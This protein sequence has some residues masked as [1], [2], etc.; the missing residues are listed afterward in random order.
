MNK[1][2]YFSLNFFVIFYRLFIYIVFKNIKQLAIKNSFLIRFQFKFNNNTNYIRQLSKMSKHNYPKVRRDESIVEN[3]H[4][5][6]V[7][8]IKF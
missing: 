4:G 7:K 2:L 6:T 5:K 8:F 1:Y 3:F